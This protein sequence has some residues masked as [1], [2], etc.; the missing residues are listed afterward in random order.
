MPW[1][2]QSNVYIEGTQKPPLSEVSFDDAQIVEEVFNES[3]ENSPY[4]N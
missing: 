4:A 2:Y 3:D 1:F